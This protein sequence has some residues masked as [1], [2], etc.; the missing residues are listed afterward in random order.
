M[1]LS[2]RAL[3]EFLGTAV[4]VM[5]IIGSGLLGQT[6][7]QDNGVVLLLNHIATLLALAVLV[8]L[9]LPISGAYINPAVVVV[10]LVTRRLTIGDGMAYIV[11]QLAGSVLGAVTAQAMF[12]RPLLEVSTTDRIGTGTF[13][14][15]VVATAGLVAMVLTALYQDRINW[16]PWLV[17]AWIGT[18]FFFTSSTSFA[19][20]AVTVGRMFSDSFTGIAPESALGFVLAQLLGALLAIA[21]VVPFD[22]AYRERTTA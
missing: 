7:S 3:A 16:L 13:I 5:A 10:M 14:G 9:L 22:R 15:E 11:V 18:A 19:N 12:E 21:L 20:P 8:A 6:L 1:S 2:I 4:L 17:P